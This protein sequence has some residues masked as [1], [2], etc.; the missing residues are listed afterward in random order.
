LRIETA[1]AQAQMDNVTRDPNKVNNRYTLVQLKTLTPAFDW[2]SY[3]SAMDAP[4][5]RCMKCRRPTS[6]AP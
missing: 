3:L 2:D 4:A 5:C 1:L 6:F